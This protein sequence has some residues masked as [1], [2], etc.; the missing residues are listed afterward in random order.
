MA[1]PCSSQLT[2]TPPSGHFLNHFIFIEVNAA[3]DGSV[4]V[5]TAD[6]EL[7]ASKRTIVFHEKGLTLV[8]A[9]L[10]FYYTCKLQSWALAKFLRQRENAA[11][12]Y[13]QKDVYDLDG[14]MERW[15]LHL[16]PFLS[17]AGAQ[18]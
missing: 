14:M 8:S 12:S 2:L 7:G 6:T 10:L 1:L 4:L 16:R 11:M 9:I 15:V 5:L 18:I 17:G 3:L 13:G